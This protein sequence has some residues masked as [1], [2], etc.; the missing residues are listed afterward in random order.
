M[1]A[2]HSKR[3]PGGLTVSYLGIKSGCTWDWQSQA[4]G[5]HSEQER[6]EESGREKGALVTGAFLGVAGRTHFL[7]FVGNRAQVSLK[8]E[9]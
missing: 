8:A 4:I 5:M 7:W 6:M 1:L 2:I 9:S 3:H